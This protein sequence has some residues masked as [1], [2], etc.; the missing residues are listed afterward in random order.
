M[1]TGSWIV[2]CI[3]ISALTLPGCAALPGPS[4]ERAP[5]DA[6]LTAP[7]PPLPLLADTTGAAALRWMIGAAEAYNDCADSKAKLV[8]AVQ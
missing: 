1:S 6:S 3:A 5:L 8:K 7:C 4:K 2:P